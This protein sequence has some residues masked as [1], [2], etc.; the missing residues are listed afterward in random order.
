MAKPE[1]F[2]TPACNN[3][4]NYDRKNNAEIT[5]RAF[6]P[7]RIPDEI[8]NG[9]ND[10]TEPFPGDNGIQFEAVGES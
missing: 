1:E 5:C 7:D 8:L 2:V 9:E 10:H 3:C 6:N 4:V